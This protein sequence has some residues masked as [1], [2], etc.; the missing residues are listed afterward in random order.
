[1]NKMT[2]GALATGIGVALLIGGGGTLAVWNSQAEA[3]AGTIIAGNMDL[4]AG[5][6]LWTNVAGDDVTA[7]VQAGQYLIVPGDSLTFT[8]PVD[9]TLSGDLMK[10]ELALTGETTST[11]TPE[12]VDV[13]PIVIKDLDKNPVAGQVLTA[14][15]DYVAST[16]F[17]FKDTAGVQDMNATYDF[18]QVG[19]LLE[20]VAPVAAETPAP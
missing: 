20:Q 18:S 4:Q 2:K 3:N 17:T 9:V 5:Q 7:Q 8:Q 6:A 19:Y 16:T 13:A 12:N 15:G 10:A 14:D 1:M 11:F